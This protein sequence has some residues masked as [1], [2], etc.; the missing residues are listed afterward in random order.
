MN[1]R[2]GTIYSKNQLTNSGLVFIV[3]LLLLNNTDAFSIHM[4]GLTTM[5]VSD[6][7]LYIINQNESS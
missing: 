5:S 6:I 4:S 2:I 7:I 3:L 1:G